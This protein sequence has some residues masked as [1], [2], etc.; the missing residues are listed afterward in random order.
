MAETIGTVMA[1]IF[2]WG[3]SLLFFIGCL[4]LVIKI[5]KGSTK[6]IINFL[7]YPIILIINILN[8]IKRSLK[9]K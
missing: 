4:M 7:T 6:I 2:V 8:F 9:A 5:F 1:G 3:F